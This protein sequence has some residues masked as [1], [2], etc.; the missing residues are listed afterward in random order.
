MPHSGHGKDSVVHLEPL[1]FT[2]RLKDGIWFIEDN[3]IIS[4]CSNNFEVF[5][6]IHKK[7]TK[8]ILK[9]VF[10]GLSGIFNWIFLSFSE[11]KIHLVQHFYNTETHFMRLPW[12][13]GSREAHAEIRSTDMKAVNLK[14]HSPLSRHQIPL[15]GYILEEHVYQHLKCL[16]RC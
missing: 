12:G 1:L 15:C 11:L 6:L 8:W 4:N 3:E 16:T 7:R 10:E 14:Q 5:K 9:C 13:T 2:S